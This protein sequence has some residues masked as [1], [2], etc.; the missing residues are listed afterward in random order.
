MKVNNQHPLQYLTGKMKTSM[1][2]LKELTGQN[3]STNSSGISTTN[4]ENNTFLGALKNAVTRESAVSEKQIT[5]NLDM[6]N[7]RI[8]R[9]MDQAEKL[10]NSLKKSSEEMNHGKSD[11]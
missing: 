7:N 6:L 11:R 4:K 5:T 1:N 10:E 2:S 8:T 3:P 9:F